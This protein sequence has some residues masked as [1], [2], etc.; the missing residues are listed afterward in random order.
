MAGSKSDSSYYYRGKDQSI[1]F[2]GTVNSLSRETFAARAQWW[3]LAKDADDG[4]V[5]HDCGEEPLTL[6]GS[7]PGTFQ[8]GG[9]FTGSVYRG[10]RLLSGRKFD[11]WAARVL[12]PDGEVLAYA[13]TN[14]ELKKIAGSPDPFPKHQPKPKR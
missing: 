1:A 6:G 11:G 4:R 7:K 5:V 3:I 2:T 10:T 8:F 13:G 12:G 9:A 14:E